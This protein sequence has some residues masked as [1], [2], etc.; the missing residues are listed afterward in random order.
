MS[1][2]VTLTQIS[3]HLQ[4]YQ[5]AYSASRSSSSWNQTGRHS[6]CSGKLLNEKPAALYNFNLSNV[7]PKHSTS[8]TDVKALDN[9][10][11]TESLP[12][13]FH[14]NSLL[15]ATSSTLLA[16]CYVKTTLN[17]ILWFIKKLASGDALAFFLFLLILLCF[18]TIFIW[19]FPHSGYSLVE[20]ADQQW[21]HW[22]WV[23]LELWPQFLYL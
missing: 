23:S 10:H 7:L 4:D 15:W 9:R 21:V 18:Q 19:C 16:A 20:R 5:S 22:S 12:E 6:R 2:K 11:P 14:S 13:P 1:L 8:L 3:R 17:N